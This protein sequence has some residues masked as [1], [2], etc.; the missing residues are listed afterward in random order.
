VKALGVAVC[1]GGDYDRWDL[2]IRRGLFGKARLLM[3]IEEHGAGKQLVRFRA[4]PVCSAGGLVLLL[5]F[6]LLSS[7]AALDHAWA[8][9][10][11]LGT[12]AFLLAFAMFAQ[13]ADA[14]VTF[15]RVVKHPQPAMYLLS[16]RAPEHLEAVG[17][18]T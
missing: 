15:G 5:L 1:R 12:L 10:L 6:A 4:W 3:A 7:G 14:L 17:E 8:A 11:L 13:C 18:R 16:N 2:E 9:A